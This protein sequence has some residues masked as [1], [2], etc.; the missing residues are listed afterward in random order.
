[1]NMFSLLI[2]TPLA[3]PLKQKVYSLKVLG[4]QG[5]LGILSNHA[6]MVMALESG[7]I[8]FLDENK[9]EKSYLIKRGLLSVENNQAVIVTEDLGKLV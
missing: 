1:M 2:M 4:E 3:S 5:Q 6:P 9:K 8:F 7:P